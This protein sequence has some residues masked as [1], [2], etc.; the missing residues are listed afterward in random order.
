[1][2]GSY[3]TT[4]VSTWLAKLLLTVPDRL[5]PNIVA[6]RRIVPEFVPFAGSVQPIIDAALELAGSE[7]ARVSRSA[8]TSEQ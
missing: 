8:A 6:G 4:R 1:M 7:D 2:V 5:L 3:R